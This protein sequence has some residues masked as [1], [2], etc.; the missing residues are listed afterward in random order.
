VTT[1]RFRLRRRW[2]F[3]VAAA[4]IGACTAV[5]FAAT[6]T[7]GSW[8][9]WAGSQTV[10]TGTCLLTGSANQNYTTDTYVNQASAGTNYESATTL[11]IKPDSGS[12]EWAYLWFNV[13]ACGVA[14][15]GAATNATLKLYVSTPPG[16]ARTLTVQPITSSE[17]NSSATWT[18]SQT[19]TYG[20]P[21][22]TFVTPTSAGGSVTISVTANSDA[23]IKGATDWGFRIYDA[24]SS[25]SN[26]TTVLYADN[27][28]T[29]D[30]PVLTIAWGQ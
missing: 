7:V 11:S 5:G 15:T 12:Q 19:V 20:T 8:H 6:L 4:A 16:S 25:A 17:N 13:P 28:P 2:I 24:G 22:E 10:S 9:L 21:T 1:R 30:V 26:D 23:W 29:A 18:N 14:T 3:V 27:G